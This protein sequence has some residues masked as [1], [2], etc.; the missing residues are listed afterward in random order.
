MQLARPNPPLFFN[1]Q[2]HSR[3][4]VHDDDY[5]VLANWSAIDHISQVLASKNKVPESHRLRFG[6]HFTRTAVALNSITV[7]GASDGRTLVQIESDTRHV[8]LTL[9]SLGLLKP[10]S[11][12]RYQHQEPDA[13]R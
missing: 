2:R 10:S 6:K 4:A 9:K 12:V 11:A 8:E 3:C 7:L 13:H 1:R 5:Y